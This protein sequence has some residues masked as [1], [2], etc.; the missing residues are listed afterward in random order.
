MKPILQKR[1]I[2]EAKSFRYWYRQKYNLPPNDPRLEQITDL[3]IL[4]EYHASNAWNDLQKGREPVAGDDFIFK[5]IDEW[6]REDGSLIDE[7]ETIRRAEQNA[8]DWDEVTI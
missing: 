6:E 1:A 3:D 8:D 7:Y 4:G 5:K 2:Q